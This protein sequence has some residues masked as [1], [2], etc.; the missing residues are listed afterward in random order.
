MVVLTAIISLGVTYPNPTLY[1]G[2]A[3]VLSSDDY[4]AIKYNRTYSGSSDLFV[5]KYTIYHPT[6]GYAWMTVTATHDKI[7]KKVD[8]SIDDTNEGVF[9][10]INDETTS[11]ENASVEPFGFRGA[12]GALSGKRVPNQLEVK[13]VSNKFEN[14]K[15]IHVLGSD[16][17]DFNNTMYFIL[18]EKN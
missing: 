5:T 9:S 2:Y 14:V 18:D 8:V 15:V 12:V 10:H 7:N 17:T 3:Y 16:K 11:Y 4:I 6:K 13:F 1:T